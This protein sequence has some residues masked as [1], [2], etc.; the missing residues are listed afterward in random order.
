[1]ILESFEKSLEKFFK[2]AGLNISKVVFEL[3]S[4]EYR[5]CSF[6]LDEKQVIYR[7]AKVTPKKTGQ[8]V[9]LWKR[10]KV[11]PIKPFNSSDNFDLVIISVQSENKIGQFVFPKQALIDKGIITHLK[12][13]GKRGFRVYPPW[14]HTNSPQARKTQKWQLEFFLDIEQSQFNAERI[15]PLYL[16]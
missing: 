9:T 11:G 6:Q 16:D 4:K 12:K 8:F 2:H 13:E 7:Q 10:V 14:D 5:A 1:M 15:K 3:E